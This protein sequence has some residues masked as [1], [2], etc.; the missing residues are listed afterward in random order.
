MLGSW[1]RFVVF[2]VDEV[3]LSQYLSVSQVVLLVTLLLKSALVTPEESSVCL[4]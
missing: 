3:T 2:L 1:S 4:Q